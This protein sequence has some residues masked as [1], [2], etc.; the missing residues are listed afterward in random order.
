MLF[1]ELILPGLIIFFFGVGAIV[2]GLICLIVE[3]STNVQ[4]ALFL[5][6]SILLLLALRKKITGAFVGYVTSR[7]NM[8]KVPD[9]FVG[10]RATVVRE[11]HPNLNGKVALHGSNWEAQADETIAEGEPVEIIGR[12]NITLRVK[13]VVQRGEQE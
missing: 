7:G 1:L 5:V 11:I 2:V 4:I 13:R 3:P 10:K 12:E 6:T 9:E 8:S